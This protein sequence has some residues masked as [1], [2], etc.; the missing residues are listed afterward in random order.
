MGHK[1]RREASKGMGM[2][3]YTRRAGWVSWDKEGHTRLCAWSV[4]IIIGPLD[5][6]SETALFH[7]VGSAGNGGFLGTFQSHTTTRQA[8]GRRPVMIEREAR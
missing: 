3:E 8:V 6:S 1:V 2:V 7:A 5:E 4:W